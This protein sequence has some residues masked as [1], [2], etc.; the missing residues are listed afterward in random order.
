MPNAHN[1][2]NH[3]YS[4]ILA[5]FLATWSHLVIGQEFL[6]PLDAEL[7]KADSLNSIGLKGEALKVYLQI[8]SQLN[9]DS[10]KAIINSKIARVNFDLGHIDIS[11]NYYEKSL[12]FQQ[13][14]DRGKDP[15]MAATHAMLGYLYRYYKFNDR[16]ALSNYLKQAALIRQFP[17]EFDVQIIFYNHYNL[18]TTYRLIED[19]QMG[20]SYAYSALDIANKEDNDQY[21]R[22]SFSV[23]ANL[24]NALNNNQKAIEAYESKIA[25]ILSENNTDRSSLP[26]DYNNLA[27]AYLDLDRLVEAEMAILKSARIQESMGVS[28]RTWLVYGSLRVK[29][30]RIDEATNFYRQA[31]SKATNNKEEAIIHAQI[32][33]AFET[34]DLYISAIEQYEMAIA[35][36]T[37]D[38][39]GELPSTGSQ[40]IINPFL[41]RI[42][43]YLA[44]T[45]TSLFKET[46]DESWLNEANEI[47]S[48]L[49]S[50]GRNQRE[51]FVTDQAKLLFQDFAHDHF[52]KALEALFLKQQ[53]EPDSD[54]ID[55]AWIYMEENKAQDLLNSINKVKNYAR[56][57]VSDSIIK[58]ESGIR[59]RLLEANAALQVCEL[60]QCPDSL[61]IEKRNNILRL[62]QSL[63]LIKSQVQK[64]HPN[65]FQAISSNPIPSLKDYIQLTGN[66]QTI[67][68]FFGSDFIYLLSVTSK[69][70]IFDR[71]PLGDDTKQGIARFQKAIGDRDNL[72]KSLAENRLLLVEN[73]A[74]LYQKL[75]LPVLDF[76]RDRL[77]IIP[78]GPLNQIPFEA[79]L[80]NK[81]PPIE[82]TPNFKDLDYLI[83]HFSVSYSFSGA[84]LLD[85]MERQSST[86]K[87]AIL[88][89]G[90]PKVSSLSSLSGSKEELR[91]IENA[92][93]RVNSYVGDQATRS[94]W[95]ETSTKNYNVIH[96]ALHASSD[97]LNP[98][99]SAIY[100][101]E[102]DDNS[103][104]QLRLYELYETDINAEL[105]ILSAC[106][107]GIGKWQKGEGVLSISKGF[108]YANNPNLI[109]SLWTVGDQVTSEL[110]RDFY[111]ELAK[112]ESIGNALRTAKLSYL[113]TADE[114]MAH[115]INWAGV[116]QMGNS[117]QAFEEESANLSLVYWA[118]GLLLV[119]FIYAFY[120]KAQAKS[121][122]TILPEP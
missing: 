83:R 9:A 19:Y 23:I 46:G 112:G 79:L 60:A 1:M 92:V 78:D 42:R 8:E 69:E 57:E 94:R 13:S 87:A 28:A 121:L 29:Q 93:K 106:E 21:R 100:F 37:A 34:A 52:E 11:I 118:L 66:T 53:I 55:K 61:L 44:R 96:L 71:L 95:N 24:Y 12:A 22:L 38:F 76:E 122:H 27:T 2:P 88:A 50:S 36:E 32:G 58:A 31:L 91:A 110:F 120:K 39:T 48:Q 20:L 119:T 41:F 113:Q 67:S 111:I 49:L 109:M 117:G 114:L 51:Q 64:D 3:V 47:Y 63:D 115:P 103:L 16:L 4:L 90:Q 104:N 26:A 102:E 5:I 65:Y 35:A 17:N 33:R 18:A 30:N 80:V 7:E 99:Y 107:T 108:A 56:L 73:G 59:T 54:L 68:Y 85:Q 10:A 72:R 86:E 70:T 15:G 62:N 84:L 77:I 6:S 116:I 74:L 45:K 14:A 81:A 97:T 82:G 89:F 25:L 43:S 98:L 40:S 105:V 101:S 75:I